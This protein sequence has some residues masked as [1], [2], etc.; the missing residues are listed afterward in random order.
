MIA[1]TAN[2]ERPQ[3]NGATGPT[4]RVG[5]FEMRVEVAEVTAEAADRW[6]HRSEALSAWLVAEWQREH[7]TEPTS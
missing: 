3:K 2:G 1:S 5:S 7:R 4:E 6:T